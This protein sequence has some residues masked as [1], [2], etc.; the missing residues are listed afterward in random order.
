MDET[1]GLNHS[2]IDVL[3]EV[4]D[5]DEDV[6]SPGSECVYSDTDDDA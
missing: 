4:E 3:P 2:R 1:W 5:S 6:D